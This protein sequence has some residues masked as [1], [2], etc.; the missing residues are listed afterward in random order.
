MS[1]KIPFE[2]TL[3]DLRAIIHGLKM[4][5][6]SFVE[7]GALTEIKSMI[8]S[9][10]SPEGINALEPGMVKSVQADIGNIMRLIEV[11]GKRD[12]EYKTRYKF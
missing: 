8:K 12:M 11:Y 9:L 10:P 1:E 4:A 7:E 3:Q 6:F 2:V 5:T